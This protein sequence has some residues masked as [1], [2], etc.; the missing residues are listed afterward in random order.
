MPKRIRS[1]VNPTCSVGR[2]EVHRAYDKKRYADPVL[3]PVARFRSSVAWQRKRKQHIA[4][5]PLCCDP[6]QDHQYDRGGTVAAE[7]VHHVVS[8]AERLDLG[9]V[10]ANLR[11]LCWA[12]H[13]QVEALY[14][15]NRDKA[16]RLFLT[17]DE[18][19][20]L[21]AHRSLTRYSHP[22]RPTEAREGATE[23]QENGIQGM[24]TVSTLPPP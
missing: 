24:D 17:Q 22:L 9:L 18:E 15:S 10:D 20:A 8:L 13:N 5:N 16:V 1:H 3:G 12:C 2:R 23:G 21:L 4:K 11:S 14:Q 6:M 7:G 19:K